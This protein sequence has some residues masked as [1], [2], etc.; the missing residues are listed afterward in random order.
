VF[1]QRDGTILILGGR[2]ESSM[3]WR[4]H[5]PNTRISDSVALPAV[6]RAI[7]T[8]LGDR[9]FFVASNDALIGVR[10]RNLEKGKPIILDHPITALAATPSGDRLFVATEASAKISVVDRYQDRVR[11]EIELAGQ[12]GELRVDPFGR[13]LLARAARGDSAWVI[14]IGTERVIG[15]VKTEWRT[16]LPFVAPDGAIALAQGN[17]VAFVDGETLR[18]RGRVAVGGGEFWYALLWSG[19]RPR[20]AALDQPVKFPSADSTDSLTPRRPADSVV[21]TPPPADTTARGFVVSFAALLS[22]SAAKDRAAQI[23]VRGQAARVVASQ[24]GGTTIYRVVLGPFATK[25]EAE[26]V[27]RESGQSYEV[28]EGVP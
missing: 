1:A 28:L 26:R 6:S 7:A 12:P 24:R 4:V 11:S 19:F 15:T 10:T 13:Y 8:Q 17:D 9:I 20:A 27:G 2:G 22:E 5:P 25:E 23:T 18:E 14:A 21:A 3:L 16:D